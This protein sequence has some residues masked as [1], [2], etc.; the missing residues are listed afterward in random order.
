MK[1]WIIVFRGPKIQHICTLL[2]SFTSS[3]LTKSSLELV[4]VS[5]TVPC[6]HKV[7]VRFCLSQHLLSRPLLVKI[8]FRLLKQL[9]VM[10]IEGEGI[11]AKVTLNDGYKMRLFSLGVYKAIGDDCTKAVKFALQK[12]GYRMIDTAALYG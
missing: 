8:E 6:L 10:N 5:F 4:P 7:P 11:Q 3:H 12:N 9:V 1:V 2:R